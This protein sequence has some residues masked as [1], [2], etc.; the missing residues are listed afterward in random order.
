MILQALKEYYDRKA[1]DPESGIAPRGWF[2]GR[3]DFAI[4]LTA[5]GDFRQLDCLQDVKDGRRLSHPCLLPY[6]G[7]QALKHT[8]SGKDA[9]LL[10][11]NATFV[12]GV[13]NK[14]NI[15]LTS[16]IA[17]IRKHLEN[18]DDPAITS[19][20]RFLENGQRDSIIFAPLIRHAQYGE[21]IRDGRV[22]LT[23][24]LLNDSHPFVIQ[25]PQIRASI[26]EITEPSKHKGVCLVTGE[27]SQPIELCHL[28]I[29]NLYGARKDPNLVS[30]NLPSFNSFGKDQSANSP[31]GKTAAFAY[32]TALNHLTARESKQKLQVGD[33]T[34]VFWSA[35]DTDFEKQIPDF[36]SEPPKDDPDRGVRAVASLFNAVQSGAFVRDV[37][38]TKFFVLGMTPFGPRIAVRFWI[39]DTVSGMA[40]KIYAYFTDTEIVVPVREKGNWP[41]RL[42]LNA[43]LAATANETK[44]DNKKPNLV[45]FRNK[46]YDVKP[47]LEGDTMR[48]ILEGLP[49]PQTL[50][51]GA[52]RRIRAE[53]EIPYPRVALIKACLNR[54]NRF[55]HSKREEVIKVSLDPNNTNIGYR[56]GRLFAAL[57]R[58]Q[59][60]ANRGRKLNTTIRSRYYGAAS[61]TPVTVFGTLMNKLNP[62][63]LQKLP[64]GLRILR[65][66]TLCQ[67]VDG[68]DGRIA[69]PAHLVIE[70]QGRFAI[71]YYHQ[72][73]Q[74]ETEQ[75]K[76]N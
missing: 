74:F 20:L 55:H 62:H 58:I 65:K 19:V 69:F 14:G 36:F 51:Q 27:A 16:F 56:L 8:N 2:Q 61:S 25:R 75:K 54:S 31:V 70:D 13:G 29:K 22:T 43:L 34:V 73:Q 47:N 37:E 10:W 59:I 7:K 28:V 33:A 15:K 26:S 63:H 6:I 30:F 35:K 39:V 76:G 60:E 32:T 5:E 4:V 72:M 3:I 50:L 57:E 64:E 48:A 9:N 23:F 71:G 18:I 42:P 21:E 53:Q 1:A 67:I 24:R 49:Y 52:I 45:R 17:A 11:D 40:G 12:L 68:V 41:Q 66:K 38:T 46:Y 44:Y